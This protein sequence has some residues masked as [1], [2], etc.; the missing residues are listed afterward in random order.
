M[1]SQVIDPDGMTPSGLVSTSGLISCVDSMEVGIRGQVSTKPLHFRKQ[2]V[3]TPSAEAES[4]AVSLKG[5]CGVQS[6]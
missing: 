4:R 1:T 5:A 3:V 2:A 6:G